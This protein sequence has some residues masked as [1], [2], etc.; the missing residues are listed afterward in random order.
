MPF[1]RRKLAKVYLGCNEM[2]PEPVGFSSHKISSTAATRPT[3]L[4]GWSLYTGV[5]Q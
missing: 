5:V 3:F 1:T 2:G 4:W